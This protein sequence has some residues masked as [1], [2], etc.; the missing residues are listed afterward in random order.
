VSV[1]KIK[2]FP[3]EKNEKKSTELYLETVARRF[4]INSKPI[5]CIFEAVL[6]AY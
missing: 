5:S 3:Q 4:L 6:A 1:N 2:G